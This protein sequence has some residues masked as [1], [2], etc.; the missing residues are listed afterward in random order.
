MTN[1]TSYLKFVPTSYTGDFVADLVSSTFD[2]LVL[3][4]VRTL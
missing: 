1:L 3:K 2:L 4:L